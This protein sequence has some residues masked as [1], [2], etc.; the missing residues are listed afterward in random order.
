[1]AG[2]SKSRPAL[3]EEILVY[4]LQNPEAIDD[5][6]GVA[7]WRLQGDRIRREV[8]GADE[9]LEWLVKRG[10]LQKIT[11]PSA[12]PVYRLNEAQRSAVERFV[13]RNATGAPDES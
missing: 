8:A 12:G 4:F 1:M 5:L 9:A 13:E 7:R 2:N 10:F 6:E 11:S 3:V